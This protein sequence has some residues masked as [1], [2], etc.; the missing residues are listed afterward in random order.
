MAPDIQRPSD[1]H[2]VSVTCSAYGR[3]LSNGRIRMPFTDLTHA[4][5]VHARDAQRPSD[6]HEGLVAKLAYG[7]IHSHGR[8]EMF[9]HGFNPT[10]L[11]VHGPDIQRLSDV[12]GP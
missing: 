9:L 1:M 4:S 5:A 11:R 6:V 12:H 3:S 10:R 8:I 2:E 7:R